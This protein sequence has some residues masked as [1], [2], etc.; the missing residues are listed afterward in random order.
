M[1]ARGL[2]RQKSPFEAWRERKSMAH[3]RSC[4]C[5]LSKLPPNCGEGEG[6]WRICAVVV[7][8]WIGGSGR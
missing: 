5:A 3:L 6:P 7:L 8:S 4:C 2:G 1:V